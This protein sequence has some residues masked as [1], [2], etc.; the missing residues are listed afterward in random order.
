M[1]KIF[2]KT[3][4]HCDDLNRRDFITAGTIGIGGLTL[5]ELLRAEQTA[6]A[7]SPTKSVINIHL[8][9]GPPHM[10]MIDLKPAAPSEIRG[11]FN[12]IATKIP[13]FQICE[14]MPKVAEIAD[15]FAFIRSLVGS[16]GQHNGFQCQSGRHHHLQ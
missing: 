10:D 15:K 11:D 6:G 2:G 12:P 4:R 13:G 7:G 1:F 9:G 5:S 14:L 3:Y 8:D 16:T